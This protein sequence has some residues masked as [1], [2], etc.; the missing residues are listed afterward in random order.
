MEQQSKPQRGA[1]L[2]RRETATPP[3]ELWRY[4]K[5]NIKANGE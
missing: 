2:D 5:N 3:R 1:A 4:V